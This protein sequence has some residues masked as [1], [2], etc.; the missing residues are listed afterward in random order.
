MAKKPEET[1]GRRRIRDLPF[2]GMDRTQQPYL[3]ADAV[4]SRAEGFVPS[5]TG[6]YERTPEW[7]AHW[8]A[9]TGYTVVGCSE[10]WDY[11]GTKQITVALKADDDSAL[12]Q[13]RVIAAGTSAAWGTPTLFSTDQDLTRDRIVYH[14]MGN[15]EYTLGW[16]PSVSP[17]ASKPFHCHL[18]RSN[19]DIWTS[20][21]FPVG[22]ENMDQSGISVTTDPTVDGDIPLGWVRVYVTFKGVDMDSEDSQHLQ[23]IYGAADH[24]A[25]NVIDVQVTGADSLYVDDLPSTSI[26][27]NTSEVLIWR[28]KSVQD[29]EQL[30][31]EPVYLTPSEAHLTGQSLTA[32]DA[33]IAENQ[34][35]QLGKF[36]FPS[37]GEAEQ[38]LPNL[39]LTEH[40]GRLACWGVKYAYRLYLAGYTDNDGV[41]QVDQNFW[42]YYADLPNRDT[43]LKFVSFRGKGYALGENGLY[44]LM[45]DDYLPSAW[46]F[47]KIADIRGA[48]ADAMVMAADMLWVIARGVAGTFG[49]YRV[50]GY[51]LFPV[52]GA[53]DAVLDSSSGV[54]SVDGMPFLTG[55]SSQRYVMLPSG[56]WGR[57]N[58]ITDPKWALGRDST[59]HSSAPMIASAAGIYYEGATY[60]AD[61]SD[62]IETRDYQGLPEE[63]TTP[64]MFMLWAHADTVTVKSYISVDGAAYTLVKDDISVTDTA[65]EVIRVPVPA[66]ASQGR[67][68][69]FKFAA[70]TA[71]QLYVDGLVTQLAQGPPEQ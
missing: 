44:R 55:T 67:R 53:I 21:V 39:G 52:G 15:A 5:S 35:L 47:R 18:F 51:D 33:D 43:I 25:A 13:H 8:S 71:K 36:D 62:Y 63:Y 31:Y 12:T 66:P 23:H 50:D 16:D 40:A 29:K 42:A 60:S 59:F 48:N 26:W 41:P 68:F 22:V 11:S 46:Y 37:V 70:Y 4:L 24:I 54:L 61:G 64:D 49:L 9:P 6:G 65:G 34:Q 57:M 2:R 19:K 3:L 30:P 20:G 58:C 27:P 32:S 56:R 14:R 38:F 45:D 7:A 69:K 28:T 10:V 17:D 1:A